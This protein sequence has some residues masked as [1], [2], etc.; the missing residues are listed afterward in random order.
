MRLVGPLALLLALAACS[1]AYE[2]APLP[3]ADD[4]V[5]APGA[6]DES[7]IP[8][9]TAAQPFEATPTTIALLAREGTFSLAVTRDEVHVSDGIGV[10]TCPLTG[11]PAPRDCLSDTPITSL[12]ATPERVAFTTGGTSR[13]VATLDD[14]CAVRFLSSRNAEGDVVSDGAQFFVSLLDGPGP[15]RSLERL[16]GSLSGEPA[17][18][19]TAT[20]TLSAAGARPGRVFYRPSA[21]T[22]VACTTGGCAHRA[23]Y[24]IAADGVVAIVAADRVVVGDARG[25][26]TCTQSCGTPMPVGAP[27]TAI[28]ALDDGVVAGTADGRVLRTVP[29]GPVRELARLGGAI[30]GIATNGAS[31]AALVASSDERATALVAL[32]LGTR[33]RG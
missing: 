8:V 13:H 32:P 17:V 15:R 29:D 23:Q 12:A 22:L 18:V 9:A 26:T 5:R 6:A 10:R 20:S 19:V 33:P 14:A 2:P 30:V 11:C 3:L 31:V 7:S 16:S 28:A 27:V 24:A 21:R 1:D 4:P 25:L